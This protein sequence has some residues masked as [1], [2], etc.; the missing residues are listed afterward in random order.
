MRRKYKQVIYACILMSV[1]SLPVSAHAISVSTRLS[2]QYAEVLGGD[3]LYFEV[4][5][6]YPE[7]PL[8]KDLQIEYQILE[9]NE[10]IVTAKMLRAVETQ[11]S[12]LDYIAIPK[13]TNRGPH[14]FIVIVEDYA[15]LH[16]EASTSFNVIKGWDQVLTYFFILLGMIFLVGILMIVQVRAMGRRINNFK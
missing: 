3:R 10:I 5:I 11:A 6:N 7:N 4:V 8:R 12:F 2:D 14:D 13:S 1:I 16:A 9:D 15:D